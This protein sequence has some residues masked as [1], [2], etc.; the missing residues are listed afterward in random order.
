MPSSQSSHGK[1]DGKVAWISGGDS[2]IGQATAILFTLEGADMTIVYK[3]GE[4][5]DAEDTKNYI[6]KTTSSSENL[7]SCQKT[8]DTRTVHL[9]AADLCDESNCT[10]AIQSHL[11]HF[12]NKLDIL[13]D[14]FALEIHSYFHVT[15]AALPH[16]PRGGSIINMVSI[17]TFIGRD[18][19]L[20]YTTTKGAVVSFTRGLSNQVVGDK[21]IRVNAICPGPVWTPL[22][23]STFSKS[24]VQDFS[25]GGGVPM[26]TCC[27]FLASED[28]SYISGNMLHPNGGVVIN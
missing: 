18:D 4:E 15:K 21:G 19:L 14:T 1:L 9:V 2:G 6:E 5:K 8:N 12:S 17:N 24:N 23:P 25:S 22:V 7:C 13:E 20:D 26:A 3:E 11:S 16:I 10:K 28:W 27:V